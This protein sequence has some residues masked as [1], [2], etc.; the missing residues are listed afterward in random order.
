MKKWF[1][2]LGMS[3]ALLVAG[4]SDDSAGPNGGQKSTVQSIV[5][6]GKIVV[7]TAPG[8]FPFDMKD[9]NGEF[10]GY[11]MDTAEAI[12]KAL[13]VEVEYKQFGFDGLIPALQTGEIDIVL[14]GMT[15][16][17]DRALAVSFANPYYK[18]G[19]ALMVPSSD[20]A[21]K[22]WEDL[23]VKGNKI[24]VTLGTTGAFLA[25]DLF[26]NAEVLDFE[27]FPSAATAMQ[28]G[29]ADGVLYDEPG[30]TVWKLRNSEAV[31][32]IK[33]LISSENLGIALRKN[34]F[35]SVQWFNSFLQSYLESPAEIASRDKWF[36][37]NDWLSEVEEN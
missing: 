37:N 3:M 34:D 31:T 29:Q 10:I 13:N 23:D 9:K 14:A 6:N 33:G 18:T 4:C 7:G 22:S 28:Q 35:E 8:Y 27:D 36:E 26:K 32:Q 12:G 17:G 16:R 15:I 20:K 21:T 2:A 19:Q 25:K 11:D 24:A 1:A 30:I 5:D